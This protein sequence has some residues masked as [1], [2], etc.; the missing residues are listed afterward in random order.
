MG[1]IRSTI[2]RS[3][4]RVQMM[5]SSQASESQP[6]NL[7]F[8]GADEGVEQFGEAGEN[9]GAK[10]APQQPIVNK[11]NIGRNDPCPCGSGKKYKKCCG[12]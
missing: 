9:G 6:K 10:S 3:I 11:N 4:F 7:Q 8:K 12:K 2:V 5:A 1:S